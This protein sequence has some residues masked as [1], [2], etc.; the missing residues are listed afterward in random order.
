MKYKVVFLLSLFLMI[1]SSCNKFEADDL[2]GTKWTGSL[3][4]NEWNETERV[5]LGFEFEYGKASFS[6]LEYGKQ[7]PETGVMLYTLEGN[8][9]TIEKA[10]EILNGRWLFSNDDKNHITLTKTADTQVFTISL[11]KR[12]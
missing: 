3:T 6:Y 11:T 9:F 12:K 7:Y 1:L 8:D 10:N 2:I 5:D 4:C